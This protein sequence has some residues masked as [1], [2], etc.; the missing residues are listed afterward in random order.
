LLDTC[1][2]T[3]AFPNSTVAH[4]RLPIA[5]Y[6]S[7]PMTCSILLRKIAVVNGLIR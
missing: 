5:A 2:L 6:D 1:S 7:L 3:T 4:H